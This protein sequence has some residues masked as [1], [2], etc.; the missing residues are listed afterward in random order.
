MV[1]ESKT[2]QRT[3]SK[4]ETNWEGPYTVL[5]RLND[6]VD[7]EI[8]TLKT[9]NPRVRGF[10][11]KESQRKIINSLRAMRIY[12]R[13][14]NPFN[15]GFI[16]NIHRVSETFDECLYDVSHISNSG[17]RDKV[18]T[19]IENYIPNKTET[20]ALKMKIILLDEKPIAQR[21]RRLSLPEKRELEKQIDEWLEQGII[22]E[23]CSYF[24]SPV[25]VRKKKDGTKRLCIDYRKL[26]K[27]IIK[28]RYPLPI[29]EKAADEKE[30][31]KKLARVLETASR[32]GIELKLKNVSFYREN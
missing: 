27:K 16:G 1:M 26:N 30:A 25:V 23:S 18:Q 12:Y 4:A 24:S 7:T 11:A 10:Y 15:T 21:S 5:K 22:R 6:V 31:Y 19:L 17:I 13:K 3:L 9:K 29:I 14:S 28:D 2:S 20:T 32:Y 8:T